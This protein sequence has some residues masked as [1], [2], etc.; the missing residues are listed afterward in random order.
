CEEAASNLSIEK[1]E[2][3]VGAKLPG[4]YRRF[5]QL[6]NGGKPDVRGFRF[7]TADGGISNSQV[8]WFF[9]L[10]KNDGYGLLDK[11]DVYGGRIP[12][13]T[14]PIACDPFGNLVLLSLNMK[15]YGAVLF[16]DHETELTISEN[17]FK[18]SDSFSAFIESLS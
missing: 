13:G 6:E 9:G 3:R 4:E 11:V 16:W 18:I 10:C 8:E 14:L 1:L 12:G 5:L 7:K 17:V 2:T 15:D